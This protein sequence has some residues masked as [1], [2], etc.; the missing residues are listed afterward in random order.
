MA[1]E[2]RTLE[3]GTRLVA[4]YKRQAHVCTVERAEE[5][6]RRSDVCY[7]LRTAHLQPRHRQRRVVVG[8][9]GVFIRG[10]DRDVL[11]DRRSG[12]GAGRVVGALGG[13]PDVDIL[14]S[15]RR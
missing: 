12:A 9:L 14:S 8:R 13:R 2:D 4:S 10:P 6:G 15:Q 11:A 1:I 7:H 3:G 5:G